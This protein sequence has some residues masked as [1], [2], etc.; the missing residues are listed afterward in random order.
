M[1]TTALEP[2]IGCIEAAMNI[3]G[4]KWTALILRDLSEA[5]KR[6]SELE[7][8]VGAINPRTL[9]QRLEFLKEQGVIEACGGVEP[10][11][12]LTEK[13]QALL[14]VLKAMADWGESYV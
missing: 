3:V 10:G 8:T 4:S 5:P 14:P 1:N 6:F 7:K 2:K 9:S 11:Y 12:R 13:G